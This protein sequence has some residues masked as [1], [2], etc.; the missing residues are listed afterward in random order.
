MANFRRFTE[1]PDAPY[2][3]GRHQMH[4][5]LAPEREASTRMGTPIKTVQHREFVAPFDQGQVGSC[6]ANAALGTLVTDPFGKQGVSYDEDD[7]V[8]LY[9]L[10]TRIDDSQIPGQY[11]PDDTGSSGPWSMLALQ[12]Q[13]LIRSWQHT[14]TLTTA[15]RLL[16]VGPI[17]IG[18]TWY[19]SMFTP[20]SSGLLTISEDDGVGGGPRSASPPTTPTTGAS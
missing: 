20:N 18:V 17:S 8:E 2:R 1:N 6:T 16:N 9:R 15:L 5:F 19:N 11:P 12:Q 4:D 7:A 13:G 3:L 10:E 14:R